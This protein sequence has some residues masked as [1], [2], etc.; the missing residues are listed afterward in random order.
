MAQA[1]RRPVI[2]SVDSRFHK[3]NN[4]ATVIAIWTTPSS[5][6]AAG[7]SPSV[8]L[9]EAAA[10]GAPILSD[11]WPGLE[12][13]FEPGREILVAG[14]TAEALDIMRHTPAREL[15]AMARRA[16]RRVLVAHTPARRAAEF[17]VYARSVR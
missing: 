8:R 2:Q 11:C 1:G 5:I 16:R 3:K 6:V 9:F 12:S 10:C 13:F 7:W 15:R 14:S 4:V 17:E